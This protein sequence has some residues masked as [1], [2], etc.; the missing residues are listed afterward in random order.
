MKLK[1]LY[2]LFILLINIPV[3]RAQEETT[4]VTKKDTLYN[5]IATERILEMLKPGKAPVVTLQLSFNYNIGHLDLA[6]DEN[7]YFRKADFVSGGTFGTRYGYGVELTGKIALH[8]QGNV[9]LNV[10]AGYNGFKSNFVIEGS[11]EGKVSYNVFSGAL[12]IENNFS[13]QKKIKPYI[14]LDMVSSFISGKAVLATDSADFNLNIKSSVRF[15]VA[16]KL[17]FE[18]AFSNRAGVNLGYKV[19]YANMIGKESK[20]SSNPGETYLNDG[21][22]TSGT[23]AFAGWKQFLYSSFYAGFNYYFGMKNK[24]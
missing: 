21:K 16:F 4:I 1:Y 2:I 9:R 17:G 13:P 22:V 12:G 10:T 11:P 20:A 19:T 7:T 15:G 6:G 3:S 5:F 18:Y 23:I 14:G 24:K 8:K